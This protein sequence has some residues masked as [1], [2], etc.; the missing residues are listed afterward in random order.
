MN[1]YN[2]F[3]GVEFYNINILKR[4][5]SWTLGSNAYLDGNNIVL[6]TGGS[7]SYRLS[8]DFV[9]SSFERCKYRCVKASILNENAIKETDAFNCGNSGV[10][11]VLDFTYAVTSGD[12]TKKQEVRKLALNKVNSAYI[13]GNNLNFEFIF[14]STNLSLDSEYGCTVTIK[15]NGSSS[16]TFSTVE[17][18]RSQDTTQVGENVTWQMQIASVKAYLDGME[19]QFSDASEK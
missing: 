18:Y 10:E 16:V 12:N 17:M 1:N 5:D 8:T 9:A 19:V 7:A 3:D 13:D 6:G 14:N 2:E 4:L 15:N 11:I